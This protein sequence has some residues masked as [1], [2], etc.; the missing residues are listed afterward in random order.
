MT[1]LKILS[2]CVATG[3]LAAAGAALAQA[4]STPEPGSTSILVGPP[5]T[6][7]APAISP[8]DFGGVSAARRGRPLP[9]GYV[10]VGHR[11][12]VTVGKRA[13]Y[14][15]FTVACP[16][17]KALRTF[18]N[19]PGGQVTAQIVGR[20]PVI[21]ERSS[22]YVGQKRWAVLADYGARRPEPGKTLIGT[23]YGLCR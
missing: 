6:I 14:P 19:Q 12:T 18:A 7:A 10:A 16:R 13:A 1:S 4:P 8:A 23:V 22:D 20:T 9:A 11:V 2:A 15:V 17:G 3:V 21:R 5:E